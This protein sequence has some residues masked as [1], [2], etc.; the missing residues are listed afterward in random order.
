MCTDECGADC[1]CCTLG[2]RR[3]YSGGRLLAGFP[4][5]DP[6]MLFECNQTCKC[7]LVWD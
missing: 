2:V 1:G 4:Y 5:H 7:N 3:W 6:P